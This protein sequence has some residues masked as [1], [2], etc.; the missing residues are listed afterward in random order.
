MHLI[1]SAIF[2][3]CRSLIEIIATG[4]GQECLIEENG[5]VNITSNVNV[6]RCVTYT[7]INQ[8]SESIQFVSYRHGYRQNQVTVAIYDQHNVK[9]GKTCELVPSG[10]V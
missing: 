3:P 2:L 8:S 7:V 5:R 10:I 1:F 9:N 6:T 4:D